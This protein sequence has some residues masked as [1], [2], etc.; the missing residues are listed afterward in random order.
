MAGE[1]FMNSKEGRLFVVAGSIFVLLIVALLWAESRQPIAVVLSDGAR[2]ELHSITRGTNHVADLRP[3]SQKLLQFA[4][5]RLVPTKWLKVMPHSEL[6]TV[7]NVTVLWL[8]VDRIPTASSYTVTDTNGYGGFISAPERFRPFNGLF[9]LVLKE[10]PRR[11]AKIALNFIGDYPQET[12]FGRLM[13]PNPKPSSAPVFSPEAIHLVATNGPLE[14]R[15]A[16]LDLMPR[17]APFPS[18]AGPHW[19]CRT[20][21]QIA[22]LGTLNQDWIVQ[23]VWLCDSGG[24]RRQATGPRGWTNGVY[25]MFGAPLWLDDPIWKVEVDLTRSTNFSPAEI[26][27]FAGVAVPSKDGPVE[28]IYRTNLLGHSITLHS[29]R[30]AQ[31]A[32]KVH[33]THSMGGPGFA[34]EIDSRDAAWV[35]RITSITSESGDRLRVPGHGYGDGYALM[36]FTVPSE[37]SEVKTLTVQATVQRRVRFDLYAKPKVLSHAETMSESLQ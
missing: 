34:I 33:G 29:M 36:R 13:I 23:S 37:K 5:K 1:K 15:L 12:L 19:A 35:P 22:E 14:L 3:L 21:F 25:E 18:M 30:A 6:Q 20:R 26:V 16:S 17:G 4:P 10:W 7:T 31:I 8:Y 2:V 11:S 9:A 27:T 28:A 24:N 32:G